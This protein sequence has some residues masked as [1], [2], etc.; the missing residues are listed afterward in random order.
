MCSDVVNR[1][2][3]LGTVQNLMFC[4]SLIRHLSAISG[5]GSPVVALNDGRNKKKLSHLLVYL[6]WLYGY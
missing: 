6:I 5:F 1:P 3:V 2:S 4:S